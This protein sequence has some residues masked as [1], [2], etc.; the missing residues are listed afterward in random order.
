M[1]GAGDNNV[2]IMDL[3]HGVFK[4]GAA[5][6]SVVF[7]WGLIPSYVQLKFRTLPPGDSRGTFGLRALCGC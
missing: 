7:G 4:V 1:V 5:C 6:G 3:E 2:H